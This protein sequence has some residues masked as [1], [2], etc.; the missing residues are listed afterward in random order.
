M[1]IRD[2]F[3]HDPDVFYL[4]FHEWPQFP[5]TGGLHEVGAGAG[6]GTTLNAAF[7]SFTT[8]DRYRQV[9]D[10]IASGPLAAFAPTWVLISAG[11]DA[12]RAD[13]LTSMGLSAGDFADLTTTILELVPKGRRLLFLEG[14]YDLDA[15]ADCTGAVLSA[16]V[17]DGSF[18]PERATSGG[19]G[20]EVCASV[21]K[22]A[23]A[24]A[25]GYLQS[26]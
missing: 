10:D 9:W 24:A 18:R 15:L 2:R 13:P 12:H 20:A 21:L 6:H 25:D 14:G 1:C 5:G 4:S 23:S 22:I 8:G 7:P 11:F 17:D 16:L 19:P 26:P 3:W